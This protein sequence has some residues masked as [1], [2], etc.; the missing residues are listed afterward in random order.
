MPLGARSSAERRRD[1][2]HFDERQSGCV[3]DREIHF[4]MSA[5]ASLLKDLSFG[6]VGFFELREGAWRWRSAAVSSKAASAKNLQLNSSVILFIYKLW[7]FTGCWTADSGVRLQSE[8]KC[9]RLNR[10]LNRLLLESSVH[11]LVLSSM[12]GSDEGS[13]V[14]WSIKADIFCRWCYAVEGTPNAFRV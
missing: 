8:G 9:H 1:K 3:Y 10:I 14:E 2:N 4:I 12:Y 11:F 6:S 7:L 13:A 5:S